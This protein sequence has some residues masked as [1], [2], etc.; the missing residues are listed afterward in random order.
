[1]ALINIAT[2]SSKSTITN[3]AEGDIQPNAYDVSIK[4][5]YAITENE[6]VIIRD[7]PTIHRGTVEVEPEV[8]KSGQEIYRLPPGEYDVLFNH[9]VNIAEGEAGWLQQRSSLNRNG[10]EVNSGLYDSGFEGWVAGRLTVKCGTL[11]TSRG[12]HLAQFILTDSESN[13]S[14][15]GQYGFGKFDDETYKE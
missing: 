7:E 15:D 12:T 6:C 4:R 2:A 14:Y 13:G 9:K 10:I 11:V 8:N 3:I 1:M 5:I